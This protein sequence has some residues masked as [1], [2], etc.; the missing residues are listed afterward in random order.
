MDRIVKGQMWKKN[1]PL[2]RLAIAQTIAKGF[3]AHRRESKDTQKKTFSPSN[4]G[5]YVGLCPRYWYLAFDGGF[6]EEKTDAM[7]VN[8][9]AFG[10]YAH[11]TIQEIFKELEILVEDEKEIAIED[12]PIRGY[13]DAIV[14]WHGEHVVCE[15]KTA[16]SDAFMRRAISGKPSAQHLIQFLIYLEATGIDK[17]F[18][19]YMNKNDQ[20]ICVIPV[21]MD[22][23]NR[24]IL[25][26]VF[27]WL[28]RVRKAWDD[29]N[30]PKRP[31]RKQDNKICNQCPLQQSCWD[32]PDGDVRIPK[33]EV[34]KI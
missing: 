26:D 30:L 19:L 27:T 28:R 4:I 10:N 29:R 12:P 21:E 5:G 13:L 17:G 14:N 16:N 8:T 20:S 34:P 23:K 22:E 11:D 24:Q 33:M 9:M 7:S 32:G 1:E 2:D 3:L 31:F 6:F 25:D 15:I 18:F